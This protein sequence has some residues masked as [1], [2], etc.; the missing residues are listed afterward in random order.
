MLYLTGPPEEFVP[1][2]LQGK[3]ACAV[4]VTYAGPEAEARE[5][6]APMLALEPEG[7]MIAEMPYAGLQC[8]LDDPP[9][10]RNYWSAE[11]LDELP[12]A[13]LDAFCAR[14]DGDHHPLADPAHHLP[15][16][17]RGRPRGR[18]LAAARRRVL[19]LG[20][21]PADDV[22]G[23][24]RRR[25]GD[26]VDAGRLRRLPSPTPPAPPTS[27]SS[28]TRARSGSSPATAART[29]SAWPRSRP[30]TTPATSSTSTTTSARWPRRGRPLHL[31]PGR[32]SAVYAGPA[33][34]P[35][36]RGR[37]LAAQE[38]WRRGAALGTNMEGLVQHRCYT[39]DVPTKRRR[40]AITETPPV[41]EALNELR[42]ELNGER[43]DIGELVILG[44]REKLAEL[45][46]EEGR[47]AGR[48]RQLADAIRI[49]PF[50]RSISRPP[51]RGPPRP[52]FR[53]DR[54]C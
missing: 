35:G 5:A 46:A 33:R 15:L 1:G 47:G 36:D 43:I 54:G 45:R 32:P 13:V 49:G 44:A 11:Y 7:Q 40:H 29:T 16:G 8:M 2:H 12:D 4:L 6:M 20:A 31:S 14:A 38:S 10:F 24:G 30:S 21:S 18:G 39:R 27:T 23:P 52:L 48:R 22:G 51:S 34:W 37:R 9:G 17:R 25:A 42:E 53:I 26:R 3:L 19:D 41:E 50:H 28:A